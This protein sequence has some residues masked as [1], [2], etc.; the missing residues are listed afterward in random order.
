MLALREVDEI[1]DKLGMA[2]GKDG[3]CLAQSHILGLDCREMA[4]AC[5]VKAGAVRV[6]THRALKR[7]RV[8]AA[9]MRMEGGR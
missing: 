2:P 5:G 6:R 1:L 9:K 4:S 3:W 8:L 7:F